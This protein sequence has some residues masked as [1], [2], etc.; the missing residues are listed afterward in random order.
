MLTHSI[1]GHRRLIK[2]FFLHLVLVLVLFFHTALLAQ[3]NFYSGILPAANLNMTLNDRFSVNAKSELRFGNLESTG[4]FAHLLS[5]LAV[6]GVYQINPHR[7][8]SVGY[9]IRLDNEVSH[10]AIQQYTVVHAFGN[11]RL[12]HRIRSDQT[13]AKHQKPRWRLR[14]RVAFQ[15]PLSG[16]KVNSKEP[17]LKVGAEM[18]TSIQAKA[19]SLEARSTPALGFQF[20]DRNKLELGLDYRLS[21]VF[22]S[23]LGHRMWYTTS[24]YLRI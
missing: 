3:S 24:W 2:E 15:V 7:R 12:S 16:Q 6:L 20:T 8:L 17:Y 11:I 13:W 4:S 9:L 23:E 10:R 19:N 5:D 14:Y 18:V 21:N 22:R 1:I